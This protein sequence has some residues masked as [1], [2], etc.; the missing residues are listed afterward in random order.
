MSRY[1]VI[2]P[3]IG[4]IASV[5]AFAAPAQAAAEQV[6][7]AVVIGSN[8]GQPDETPLLYAERDAERVADV[9]VRLASVTEENLLLL[10]GADAKRLERVIAGIGERVR[11]KRAKGKVEALLFVYYSGHASVDALHLGASRMPFRRLRKLVS[12]IGADVSVFVVDA[13]RS[14]GMTRVKGAAPA[15]PFE[16]RVEDK[17][18]STG[19][20]IITSSSAGEDAQES[21][22]LNG[23]IFTHHLINGLRGA[24]D[25]SADKRVTIGEAY[26]YA[27]SQTLRATSRTRFVQ[28]PTYSFRIKGK[29]ELTLTRTGAATG[30]G[31]LRLNDAGFYVIMDTTRGGT[32]VAELRARR[33]TDV[34]L[35]RGRYLVRR[36]GVKMVHEGTVAIASGGRASL[37]RKTMKRMPYGRTVRRGLT[38][39]N[40]FSV[41]LMTIASQPVLSGQSAGLFGGVGLGVETSGAR[42]Q[43]RMRYGQADSTNTDLTMQQRMLGA[44]LGIF[45]IF[46][47]PRLNAGVGLGVRLGGDWIMQRFTTTGA[48]PDRDQWVYRASPALSMQFAPQSNWTVGLE[49]G[50][51][52]YAMQM[53]RDGQAVWENPVAP[54]CAAAINVFLP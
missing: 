30:Q 27:Y 6:R 47:L 44:D 46:D 31:R 51:D 19:T 10:R 1:R 36:R 12:G 5:M 13:C 4:L 9:L 49:C 32:V 24:A 45:R 38:E 39:S 28:H 3:I 16:I 18:Q 14:G 23:G 2:A 50:I 7:F 15:A 52:V 22:R 8:D 54:F 35:P 25:A 34:L 42:F 26:H 43:L 53:Q 33:K 21:E 40:P 17:L 29:Q 41:G 11:R 48:A 20:A 37:S